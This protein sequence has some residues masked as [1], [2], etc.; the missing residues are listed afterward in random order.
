M[1]HQGLSCK[2]N[3]VSGWGELPQ[4]NGINLL[5]V[6]R[7]HCWLGWHT[8]EPSYPGPQNYKW[9]ASLQRNPLCLCHWKRRLSS[10]WEF[11]GLDICGLFVVMIENV[12]T[13][14]FFF[15]PDFP[16]YFKGE[17][18]KNKTTHSLPSSYSPLLACTPPWRAQQRHPTETPNRNRAAISVWTGCYF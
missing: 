11:N 8:V 17:G 18:M 5:Q 12:P 1:Q 13:S 6:I 3:R 15:F 2:L 4:A 9:P 7:A 10:D 14:S 16:S